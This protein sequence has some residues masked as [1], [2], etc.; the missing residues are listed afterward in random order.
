MPTHL[1][2]VSVDDFVEV[3]HI[4]SI[5]CAAR[6]SVLQELVFTADHL[7]RR[8]EQGTASKIILR[9]CFTLS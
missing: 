8:V 6:V 2:Q 3:D 1:P 4:L 7:V 9:E 5:P